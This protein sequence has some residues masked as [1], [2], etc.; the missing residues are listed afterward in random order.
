MA[1]DIA[2]W[3]HCNSVDNSSVRGAETMAPSKDNP[4]VSHLAKASQ[5]LSRYV[6][7]EYC[8]ATGLKNRGV[9]IVDNMTGINWSDIPVTIIELGFMSNPEEDQLMQDPAMK[10]NMVQ[11][12]ADGIDAYFGLQ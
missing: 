6:I 4:Y 10:N 8:K 3:V 5:S 1:A 12:M 7:D 9:Q 2:I 11:G